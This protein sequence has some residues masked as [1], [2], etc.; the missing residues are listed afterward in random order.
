MSQALGK[1]IFICGMSRSGTT[2]LTTIFDSH[3]N[4]SMGY[5]LLPA[6][7]PTVPEMISILESKVRE[8]NNEVTPI[9]KA[10]KNE[11]LDS[12]SSFVKRCY[13]TNVLPDELLELLQRSR[14]Q[15]HFNLA[16][17]DIKFRLA[18]SHLV[19]DKKRQKEQTLNQGF[20]LNAAIFE[21]AYHLNPNSNFI[22]ILRDPRDVVASHFQRGFDR[23]V[24]QII[25]AW[26]NYLKNFI[27]FQKKHPRNA[28]LIRYEDLVSSP[29]QKTKE[30]IDFCQLNYV[31]QVRDFFRS[32]A[33]I[34]ISGHAN[35][36]NLSKD[37]FTSSVGRWQQD[38]QTETIC[39]IEKLCGN[40]LKEFDYQPV[41]TSIKPIDQT[42]FEKKR[43]AFVPKRKFNQEQYRDLITENTQNRINL[44]WHQAVTG[45][46]KAQGED[47]F[48]VRH[49]IDHDIET[50]LRLA[51]WEH[52]YGIQATYCVLHTAWYYGE[53]KNGKYKHYD[54]MVDTCKEIQGL[55]HEINLHN[56]LAVLALQTGC[57]PFQILE[58]ELEFFDLNGIQITGTSTHGDRLC[59]ELN[60]RNYELFSESVYE[61]RGGPRTIS[62]EGNQV[63]LGSRSM[64][65]FGLLYEGYDL[66]RDI[67]ITDSG[68]ELRVIE[69]TRGRGGRRREEIDI[70]LPYGNILGILTH[71]LWWSID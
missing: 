8:Y 26:K 33:S 27:K 55:G 69:G 2:L 66:P 48:L 62:W 50:A 39:E 19:V 16:T 23:T 22:Y 36:E 9:C 29:D 63:A 32:K 21:E 65:E 41:G 24:D 5:E 49:D 68:G 20:K 34:H 60:F 25:N 52:E 54:V 28:Y 59:R 64:K 71:P 70:D 51:R 17:N 47:I 58:D 56:N 6:N 53:F 18:I 12:F 7:L 10:I 40:F 44:T 35:Q 31:N 14:K 30:L 11:G 3:P 61:S 46:E 42:I 37:F 15:E 38:L 43:T 4:V 67:Y 57:N 1:N 45:L 13:R